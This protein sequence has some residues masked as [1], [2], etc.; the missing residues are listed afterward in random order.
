MK[1]K[2]CGEKVV[3]FPLRDN[4]GKLIVKNLFRI[5]LMSL[6]GVIVVILLAI[7]YKADTET[8]REIISDPINYCDESNACKILEEMESVNPYGTI[9]IREI[10]EINVSG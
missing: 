5:D 8:C 4:N 6:I 3:R 2:N 9:D 7:T 1:C 10:P